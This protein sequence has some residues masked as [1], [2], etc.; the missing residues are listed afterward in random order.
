MSCIL[1]MSKF[2]FLRVATYLSKVFWGFA[3]YVVRCLYPQADKARRGGR[4]KHVSTNTRRMQITTRSRSSVANHM[5]MKLKGGPRLCQ[6]QFGRE[7]LKPLKNFPHQIH[8]YIHT[9]IH[10]SMITFSFKK[11]R[12]WFTIA[13]KLILLRISS[14]IS[15]KKLDSGST[16]FQSD[17]FW[18]KYLYKILMDMQ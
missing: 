18:P 10:G 13:K 4:Y 6:H 14:I 5:R 9:Y 2:R 7:N 12:N 8:I 15:E 17:Q 16:W 11:P 1:R 3:L